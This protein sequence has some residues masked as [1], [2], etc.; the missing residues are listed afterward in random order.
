M[1]DS[2][3]NY[4]QASYFLPLDARIL[5]GQLSMEG[6]IIPQNSAYNKEEV[7]QWEKTIW[8]VI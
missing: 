3:S 8:G 5:D 4:G 2:A 6:D 7:R 1:Q